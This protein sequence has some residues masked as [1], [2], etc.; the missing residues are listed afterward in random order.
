VAQEIVWAGIFIE[1]ADEVGYGAL[2]IRFVCDRAVKQNIFGEFLNNS[3]DVVG[4]TLEHFKR[5]F[6]FNRILSAQQHRVSDVKQVV[7]CNADVDGFCIFRKASVGDHPFVVGVDI[8]FIAVGSLRPSF[9]GGFMLLHG[10]VGSFDDAD[11]YRSAFALDALHRPVGELFLDTHARRE[12]TP[13][14]QF[15]LNNRGTQV[16]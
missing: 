5:D 12:D 7:A 14:A 2:K 16:R 15:L 10:K 9:D 13:G 8:D 1:P 4:H 11:F 6:F 3:A